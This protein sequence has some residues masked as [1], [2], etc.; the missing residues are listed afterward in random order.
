MGVVDYERYGLPDIGVYI[1]RLEGHSMGLGPRGH[2][3]STPRLQRRS[4]RP[5][6]AMVEVVDRRA[7]RRTIFCR[8]VRQNSARIARTVFNV[9]VCRT[10]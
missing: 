2:R 3:G 10:F 1:S 9:A 6:R 7:P 8:N 4:R 5:W